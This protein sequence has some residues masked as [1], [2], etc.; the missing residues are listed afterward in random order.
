M[1]KIIIPVIIAAICWFM[2]FSP[3]T[4]HMVNFWAGIATSTSLLIIL[5]LYLDRK[6]L[7]S[8]YNFKTKHILI[9]I[10]SAAIL[11]IVFY[12]GNLVSTSIFSFA[13]S[14]ISNIYTNK[15]QSSQFLI[16]ILL[17]FLIGPAEEIFWRGFVQKNFSDKYGGMKGFMITT[18]IYAAV[19]IWSFNFI[20]VMA[21]LICGLFWGY[22]FYRYKS[23]V[24]VIIS[25]SIWDVVIFII[26]PIT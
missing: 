16:G 3:W 11:Y 19:H 15:E 24:P 26:L 17:F 7:S 21:A 6:E 23:I 20:L 9:G 18:F 5:A 10:I 13:Q 14:Q 8:V 4:K 12:T 22:M 25:H 2:M 1:K